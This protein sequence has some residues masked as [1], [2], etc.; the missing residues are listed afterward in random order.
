MNILYESGSIDDKK[1]LPKMV[2]VYPKIM[3]SFNISDAIMKKS[4]SHF[5][6]YED[7]LKGPK[8]KCD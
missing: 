4:L 5:N 6:F 1:W 2:K 8:F 3:I 7:W